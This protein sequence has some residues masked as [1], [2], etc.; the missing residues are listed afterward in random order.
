MS[1]PW[2]RALGALVGVGFLACVAVA[3]ATYVDP[4]QLANGDA[5]LYTS[6]ALRFRELILAG[7]VGGMLELAALPL[8]RPPGHPLALGL[9]AAVFGAEHAV[10]RLYGVAATALGLGL[11]AGLAR[12]AAGEV[13]GWVGLGAL[14]LLAAGPL[15]LQ[16]MF[17]PMT[18]PSAGVAVAAALGVAAWAHGRPGP[19]PALA[20]GLAV[21]AAGLVR[22]NFWLMLPAALLVWHVV[23]RWAGP[24]DRASRPALLDPSRLLWLAPSLA[25]IAVWQLVDRRFLGQLAVFLVNQGNNSG[26]STLS[27]DNWMWVPRTLPAFAWNLGP[28]GAAVMALFAIG[29]APALLGR[30]LRR[31]IDAGGAALALGTS[32]TLRLLQCWALV[33]LL[34]LTLHPFKIIR[35]LH[36][37]MPAFALAMALPF[38]A[39]R[40]PGR[41]GQGLALA[42]ALAVG[43]RV[44]WL[45]ARVPD[46]SEDQTYVLNGELRQALSRVE[47]NLQ[48]AQTL[49][50][51]GWMQ[52]LEPHLWE[53]WLRDRGSSA[54]V[55]VGWMPEAGLDASQIELY[56][57][58]PGQPVQLTEVLHAQAAARATFVVVEAGERASQ[59]PPTAFQVNASAYAA[60]MALTA[61]GLQEVEQV[62]LPSARLTLHIW[63]GGG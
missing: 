46:F 11:W 14:L 45:L 50:V 58:P 19:W 24:R 49:A 32:P 41:L 9:W 8:L 56:L 7:D 51:V 13:G 54:R 18:E 59:S 30:D 61:L 2:R 27:L 15:Y 23:E 62:Q 42:L 17:T 22:Y 37:L 55:V 36:W 60:T 38:A 4:R 63:T 6:M 20:T 26:A 33:G 25:V 34:A 21:A 10:M 57:V 39:T 28:A 3:H 43:G 31:P 12:R 52:P 53:I 44:G 16:L 35:N 1:P 48:G 40:A 29:L 5:G 47:A